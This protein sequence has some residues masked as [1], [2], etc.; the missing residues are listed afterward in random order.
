M[1]ASQ[2]SNNSMP[3]KRIAIGGLH[4]IVIAASAVFMIFC[5]RVWEVSNHGVVSGHTNAFNEEWS[6]HEI[7]AKP[8]GAYVATQ[9]AAFAL[10][11]LLKA[12]NGKFI[13]PI[14]AFAVTGFIYGIWGLFDSW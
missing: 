14:I 6:K 9:V 7:V 10:V 2:V 8:L 4:A 1:D 13:L 11:V 3:T 12:K 5:R